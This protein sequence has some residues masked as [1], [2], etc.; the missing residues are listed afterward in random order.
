MT[1]APPAAARLA[2]PPG[3]LPGVAGRDPLAAY[4]LAQVT[5]RLRREVCWLWRE[6]AQQGAAGMPGALPAVLA[7]AGFAA[8]V[9]AVLPDAVG[10][11]GR[12]LRHRASP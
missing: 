3:F 6:R 5:L 2:E 9:V 8:L 12:R 11:L 4:W 1:T 10:E 7:V